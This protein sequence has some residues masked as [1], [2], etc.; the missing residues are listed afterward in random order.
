MVNH[1]QKNLN[2]SA[3]VEKGPVSAVLNLPENATALLILAHGAGASMLHHHMESITAALARN[4]IATF[5]FNFPY[6][7]AGGKRTDS[8]AVCVQTFSNA[9][10]SLDKTAVKL[11]LFI[12]GHSFGGRM[13][14]HFMAQEIPVRVC[15]GLIY[16]SFPLH[17]SKKPNIKRADHLA[18]IKTPMLFLSGTRDTLAE[19]ELLEQVTRNIPQAKIHWLETA[20][21][22]FKILKRTRES[23]ED[24]YDEAARVA[25]TFIEEHVH[26]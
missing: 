3:T 2:F 5:R 16:F 23:T 13:S 12:G 7:E 26:Y 10:A 19:S 9:V 6:M 15:R 18:D 22:G 24:V 1:V 4:K 14:S 17:P 21:H 20:D 25:A 11:P 8:M